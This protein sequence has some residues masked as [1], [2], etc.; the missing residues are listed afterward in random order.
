MSTADQRIALGQY[1]ERVAARWL[2][3]AGMVVLER[4]WR[5]EIG[6]LDLVLIEG[7]VLVVCEVKTRSS[8]EFGNPLEAVTAT[9]AARLRRLA[10]RWLETHDLHPSDVRIDLVGVLQDGH[11]AA[12]VDHVRGVA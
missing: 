8:E 6:E 1:G 11:G 4:N 10:A 2:V 12:L 9:K 5:C 3:A 7:E